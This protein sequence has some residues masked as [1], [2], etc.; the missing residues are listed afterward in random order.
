MSADPRAC[1]AT[2][3]CIAVGCAL[4]ASLVAL[5]A[6]PPADPCRRTGVGALCLDLEGARSYAWG[7]S[8]SAL[9]VADVDADGHPDLVLGGGLQG[10]FAVTWGGPGGLKDMFSGTSTSWSVGGRMIDLAVAD[11]DGDGHLDL[12]A[13]LP[14]SD[15]IAVLRGRGGRAFAE[16]ERIAVG[17]GPRSLA[18]VRLDADG[19]PALVIANEGDGTVTVLRNFV[20]AP[21]VPVGPGPRAIT[22]GDLD[23][24]GHLDL[25][26]AVP[27][28]GAIQILLGDGRGGLAAGPRHAVG[29]APSAVV[30]ADLDADGAVDL[31]TLD[32]LADQVTILHG[33]GHARLRARTSWPVEPEPRFPVV[34]PDA[35]GQPVLHVMSGVTGNVQR[36]D[37][38]R[39]V[40]VVGTPAQRPTSLGAGDLDGDGRD[41]LLYVDFDN[42]VGEL[43]PGPG[44]RVATLWE[45]DRRGVI[46]PVDIDGDGVDELLVDLDDQPA[47][48]PDAEPAEEVDDLPTRILGLMRG[49]ELLHLELD[50]SLHYDLAGAAAGDF[51]GDGRRDLAVWDNFFIAHLRGLPDGQ[52]APAVVAP[53]AA[54]RVA[55]VVDPGDGAARLLF[56]RDDAL[57]ALAPDPEGAFAVAAEQ[58]FADGIVSL[59]VVDIADDGRA[60]LLVQDP[61]GLRVL[62]DMRLDRPAHPL[63][64][65]LFGHLQSVHL[66]DGDAGGRDA[67]LCGDSG[68]YHV[69]DLFAAAPRT[70]VAIEERKCVL[71][72]T[73]DLDEDGREELVS[74]RNEFSF[75]D[76]QRVVLTP[77]RRDDG[78]WRPLGSRAVA[79]LA[80][81][82]LAGLGAGGRPIL[83]VDAVF[84]RLVA[85]DMS[86]GT[87]F[88]ASPRLAIRSAA[89]P[90][91]GDFDGDGALDLFAYAPSI[92]LARGD[93]DGGFGPMQ[94]RDDLL[95]DAAG[96][97][98]AAAHDVD[99]DGADEVVL[100][101]AVDDGEH[102]D[103]V[104]LD[105]ED[106][107]PRPRRLLRLAARYADFV[108]GD[109]DGDRRLD[110]L[111]ITPESLSGTSFGPSW[112]RTV[113]LRG[114]DDGFL[115][116]RAESIV[117][118]ATV[119][120]G[121]SLADLD[122]DGRLDLLDTSFAL[123]M[124]PGLG[125]GRFGPSRTWSLVGPGEH[126]VGDLD[127]DGRPDLVGV[128]SSLNSQTRQFQVHLLLLRGSD[129]AGVPQVLAEDL[130]S[131]D[132][133]DLDGD[134]LLELL[135]MGSDGALHLGR[136]RDG[137]LRFERHVL[138]VAAGGAV[139][140]RDVDGDDLLD[141]TFLN[142]SNVAI[143]RQS[144]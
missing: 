112:Y 21:P 114:S 11:L 76:V 131:V 119:F 103:L 137:R 50:S 57:I 143:V 70:P 94:L 46:F 61:F 102:Y 78:A 108:V 138:P 27:E 80:M 85:Q 93:G 65:P 66:V 99:G 117:F 115:D 91:L 116:P 110:L 24:D 126:A 28:T 109:L 79:A 39:G 43:E 90:V 2:S 64:V 38:R 42:M 60:D 141:I 127:S 134:G 12:A 88:V 73:L 17:D 135:A 32:V 100:L 14:D 75:G 67:V 113:L 54:E 125:D 105:V 3:P 49:R 15:E 118:N 6:C 133:A 87:A 30:A 69:A 111:V 74:V 139:R 34:V 89:N 26:V 95:P 20:A 128:A 59:H 4:L 31:A 55:P 142:R 18:A 97:Q 53:L 122:G 129:P 35:D 16:I 40:V 144:P 98:R 124:A 8:A 96:I 104:R 36:V 23:G 62:E 45:E 84:G 121:F 83:L 25:A 82:R 72:A 71:V 81:P 29:L 123:T 48:D 92:G 140:A 1:R 120:E 58:T 52:F 22:S 5:A 44:L 63:D 37:P 101:A 136:L 7:L 41:S 77:W 130:R 107:E 86:L 13:A 47:A 56:V 68:L 19:P 9:A 10:A 51:D 33:D 106:G 132:L